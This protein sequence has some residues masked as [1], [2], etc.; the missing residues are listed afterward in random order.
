MYNYKLYKVKY[1]HH[2]ICIR[3]I[4]TTET[5]Y[6][7]LLSTVLT[8][9]HLALRHCWLSLKKKTHTH[10]GRRKDKQSSLWEMYKWRMPGSFW[11]T[12]L[13]PIN[14]ARSRISCFG[15]SVDET[16]IISLVSNII[17]PFHLGHSLTVRN[18][19]APG[20][21]QFWGNLGGKGRKI[22]LQPNA[23]TLPLL[24]FF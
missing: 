1:G 15:V 6:W 19:V 14:C 12:E 17:I 4:D 21:G 24:S 18:D 8:S 16:R 23:L 13:S 20:E 3:R 7:K 2:G 5:G 11:S 10:K 22:G 9:K